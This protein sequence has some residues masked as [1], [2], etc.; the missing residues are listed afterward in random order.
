MGIFGKVKKAAKKGART[1][2]R[3]VVKPTAKRI[4][5]DAKRTYKSTAGKA[6]RKPDVSPR[7]AYRT[8]KRIVGAPSRI[9]RELNQ[10]GKPKKARPRRR[11]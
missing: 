3:S 9:A 7:K 5:S 4:G 2:Y 1:T 11:R 6:I 10:A 8:A